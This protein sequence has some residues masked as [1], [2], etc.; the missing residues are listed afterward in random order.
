MLLAVEPRLAS[1]VFEIKSLRGSEKS[2]EK[3]AKLST[4]LPSVSAG[5]CLKPKLMSEL[6][7]TPAPGHHFLCCFGA[8]L[9]FSQ[10][11][12]VYVLCVSCKSQHHTAKACVRSHL[13]NHLHP[14][15]R[16]RLKKRTVGTLSQFEFLS[17]PG[18]QIVISSSLSRRDV[19]PATLLISVA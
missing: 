15:H 7:T 11:H 1:C 8:R 10:S 2:R 19:L 16:S 12:C 13:P 14:C 6:Q 9:A 5:V 18:C 4:L 3:D 17:P